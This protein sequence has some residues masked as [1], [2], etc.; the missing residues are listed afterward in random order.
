MLDHKENYRTQKAVF[1]T[2]LLNRRGESMSS[3]LYY[4]LNVY[5]L[6]FCP[7]FAYILIIL[8]ICVVPSCSCFI[9][10]DLKVLLV[11][12]LLGFNAP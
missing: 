11:P 10:N 5:E 2:L 4:Q 8:N 1:L 9:L 7:Y 3:L 6:Y 12:I